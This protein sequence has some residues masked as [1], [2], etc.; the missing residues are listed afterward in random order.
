MGGSLK[1]GGLWA[2]SR[3][4]GTCR[5]GVHSVPRH[6]SCLRPL[7]GPLAPAVPPPAVPDPPPPSH[8]PYLQVRSVRVPQVG[9]KF[10]SRHGQKGTIGI[11]YTQVRCAGGLVAVWPNGC[12]WAAMRRQAEGHD[13]QRSGGRITL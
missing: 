4:H 5:G 10:A 12:G 9:D 2:A 11:T 3:S 8:T 6:R 13:L 1:G 7:S